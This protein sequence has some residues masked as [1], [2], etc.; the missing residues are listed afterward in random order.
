MPPRGWRWWCLLVQVL[1][2]VATRV[3]GIITRHI[4]LVL[5]G[6]CWHFSG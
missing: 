3:E 1:R 4:L 6:L 5:I 2:E